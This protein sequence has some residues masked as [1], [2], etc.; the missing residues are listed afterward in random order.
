[1]ETNLMYILVAGHCSIAFN[2]VAITL[3]TRTWKN[4]AICHHIQI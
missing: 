3:N 1:M 2:T 4:E